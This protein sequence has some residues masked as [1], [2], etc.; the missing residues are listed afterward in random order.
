[1]IGTFLAMSRIT[2]SEAMAGVAASLG[3]TFLRALFPLM[4]N[5][6]VLAIKG[7]LWWL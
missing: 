4:L 6:A 1:M 2:S 3:L 5:G 7:E